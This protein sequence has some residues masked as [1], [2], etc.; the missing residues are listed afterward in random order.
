MTQQHG[1]IAY[2]VRHPVAANLLMLLI[3]CMGVLSYQSIQRQTFPVS[4]NHKVTI[5]ATQLGASVKE[6]EENILL[7]IEQAL[8]PQI[9]IKRVLSSATPSQAKVEVEL[10]SGENIAA[11]LD[12]IKLKLDSI[13]SFPTAMEPLLIFENAQQQRAI[14]IVVSGLSDPL[15]LKKLGNEIKT[16]LLQLKDISHV[17]LSAMPNYEVSI[18]I[19]PIKLREFSLSLSQVVQA[20]QSHSDNLSAG[21]IKTSNGNI[22]LRLEERRYH[23]DDLLNLPVVSGLL[24]ET[25]R[26]KDIATIKDGFTETLDEGRLNGERAVYIMVDA[27]KEQSLTHVV[28]TAQ[29]YLNEK[30]RSLPSE[31]E[32]YEFVDV[33][34]YLEGRLNMML[35][36]L[37]QGAILVFIL[38][39]VFLRTR[40]AVW[41]MIGLPVSMLGAFWL[42]PWLGITINL[43]S[44][45]AFIMVLGI[46]VDDAIVIG[47]SVCDQVES[48]GHNNEQVILGTHKV[49]MPA[50]FGV[51][52][53]IAIFMPF[54]LS[55]GPNSGQFI[56]IAGVCILCLLFSLVESKLILPAHLAHT[57]MPS[58][59]NSHWRV[60]FNNRLQHL[61]NS[62]FKPVL[63]SCIHHRYAVILAFVSLLIVTVCLIV[64]GL[65]RFVAVPKVP[66]DFPSINIQMN[67]NVSEAQ[68][69]AA[70]KEIEAMIQRVE[71]DTI[72]QTNQPMMRTMY[73]RIDHLTE[74]E[75]V[76]P[77]VA[78]ADRPFDTFELARRW[79]A[80]LPN[81][82]GVKKFTIE[83][84]VIDIAE[85]GD[86]EY[87]LFADD[88]QTLQR[89]S[90]DFIAQ[91]TQI[92]GVHSVYSSMDSAQ[93]EY[94]V[95]L[96]PIAYQLQ[97]D[98]KTVTE[99]VAAKFYGLELQRVMREGQE[100]IFMVRGAR[101][102]RENISALAQ[103]LITLPNGEQVFFGDIANTIEAPS[104][105]KIDREQGFQ[106]VT[107]SANVDAQQAQLSTVSNK[108]EADILPAVTSRYTGVTTQLGS[109]LL[110][111]RNE[112]S[113]ML[114]FALVGLL[115]IYL[116]LALPL[117]SY[118]QPLIVMSVIPFSVIGA[119]WGHFLF[120]YTL[121]I[122]SVFGIVAA[123]GVVINDSLVMT[124]VINRNRAKG[125]ALNDAVVQASISRFRAIL[126]TSLTTFFGLVPIMFESSL[127][128]QF[129]IPT[130]ISL[131]FSVLFATVVT[132]IM[133]PCLYAVLEDVKRLHLP[134]MRKFKIQNA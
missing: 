43:V 120:G 45:F 4:D 48:H 51:L 30:R 73:T 96:K 82:P 59:P 102:D 83:S 32:L 112:R 101:T 111:Q 46:V 124:D 95:K 15:L 47:E 33:T 125:V 34:F 20:I 16:E 76:V 109:T 7:K 60:R 123:A 56:A 72:A 79:Q 66:H 108:I 58:L 63:K 127:Q 115:V 18:E 27:S 70:V 75:I 86:L 71:R 26:L 94:K 92:K 13:A 50:T 5:Q 133:V 134:L 21:H 64:T 25:I 44:L 99:Q 80:E 105:A 88:I 98:A 11:R 97:L 65:V 81:I 77:L 110:D 84:D 19:S 39:A 87:R 107:I 24:G 57:R 36:N 132:L 55:T 121:S 61:L 40:L 78:E 9:G 37:A 90:Q 91:L 53:T 119:L 130:A 89:A 54:M 118:V 52:T 93:T 42:M 41:V 128:A 22:Y 49:A 129:V 2:F 23:G 31:I 122:M 113:Q 114:T 117:K 8:K 100:V 29:A 14:S 104:V 10:N 85:K 68:T 3:V 103:T 17:N 1:L 28:T 67:Q 12:E 106:V 131:S 38:L 69:L 116:L 74:A 126:L 62:R 35:E 6:V